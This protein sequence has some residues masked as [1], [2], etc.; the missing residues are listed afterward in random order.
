LNGLIQ[1]TDPFAFYPHLQVKDDPGH[2]FYLGVEL[3]RAQIAWQ[4]GKR[5]TQDE[6]LQ[7]GCAV[8]VDQEDLTQQKTE[9][10]TMKKRS[11]RACG[12]AEAETP[13]KKERAC[14][15]ADQQDT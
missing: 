5:Y 1:D 9:G 7:W 15:T 14:G 3:A 2:A 13:I 11:Q 10:T 4:L 8:E 12:T 6:D